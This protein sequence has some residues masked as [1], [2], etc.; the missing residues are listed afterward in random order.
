MKAGRPT[1]MITITSDDAMDQ[2]NHDA[3]RAR[4]DVPGFCGSS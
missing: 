1:A 2:R 4:V 3:D